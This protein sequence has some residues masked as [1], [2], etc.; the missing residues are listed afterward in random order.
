MASTSAPVAICRAVVVVVVV[1]GTNLDI[2]SH[3]SVADDGLDGI[4]YSHA[5]AVNGV[6]LCHSWK[7]W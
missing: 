2:L 5:V 6:C 4:L 7:G 1:D 3:Y